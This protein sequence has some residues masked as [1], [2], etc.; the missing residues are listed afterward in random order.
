MFSCRITVLCSNTRQIEQMSLIQSSAGLSHIHVSAT[1]TTVHRVHSMNDFQ[2]MGLEK[3]SGSDEYHKTMEQL[4]K[5]K[6]RTYGMN[7]QE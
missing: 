5:G 3:L 7:V 6:L 2:I 4:W 1:A